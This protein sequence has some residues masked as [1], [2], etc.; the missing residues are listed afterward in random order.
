YLYVGAAVRDDSLVTHWDFPRMSYPWDTDC[1]EVVLDTRVNSSQ[2]YDPPT[3]G[4]YRH[5]SMAEH[6]VTDFSAEMWQ[7]AGAGG[8]LLPKPNLAPGAETYFHPTND[9]YAI[10]ARYPLSSLGDIIVKPGFK[11]GF[12][13]A[14]NDND[15]TN[16]R[17]NQHIWAGYNQ[18][19]SWWDIGTIGALVF[20][21]H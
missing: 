9:G 14:I 10:V 4:L 19:Q 8:P 3:P 12:D 13:V 15:G 16:Y 20:G 18:N 1:M 5:L 17:K 21:P 6:R 2:G 7:G 11:I